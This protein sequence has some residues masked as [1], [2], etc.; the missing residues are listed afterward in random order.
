MF[1]RVVSKT[2]FVLYCAWF[3]WVVLTQLYIMDN[4]FLT[5][6]KGRG[7]FFRIEG[8][9]WY[10]T[11]I[12][13]ILQNCRSM[14]QDWTHSGGGRERE[15]ERESQRN[16]CN[17]QLTTTKSRNHEYHVLIFD[18]FLFD[19]RS[20]SGSIFSYCR[21]AEFIWQHMCASSRPAMDRTDGVHES[22][23]LW[24]QWHCFSAIIR[25]HTSEIWWIPEGASHVLAWAL[26]ILAANKPQ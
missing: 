1:L 23:N 11:Y 4:Q 16:H 15:R 19:Y 22:E 20:G 7:V 13:T 14:A 21:A 12:W 24:S 5:T 9:K 2:G 10:R 6:Y 8:F 25:E 26:Q 3:I 18:I 17:R